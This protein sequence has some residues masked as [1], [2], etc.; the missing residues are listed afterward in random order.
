MGFNYGGILHLNKVVKM[1]LLD[2]V[3]VALDIAIFMYLLFFFP[4]TVEIKDPNYRNPSWHL[5]ETFNFEVLTNTQ[6]YI[7]R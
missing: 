5:S 4:L 7:P 1:G 3:V 6:Y 2:Y